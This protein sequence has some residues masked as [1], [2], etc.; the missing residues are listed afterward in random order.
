V[1]REPVE[2]RR[3]HFGVAEDTRPVAEREVGGHDDG[4]FL[5]K[6]AD[7]VE[8]QLPTRLGERQVAKLVQND[9]VEPGSAVRP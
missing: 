4:G 3:G 1:V 6:T 9:Q 7:Q 5:I 2:E 8:Q